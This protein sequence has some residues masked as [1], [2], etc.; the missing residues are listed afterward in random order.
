MKRKL[1]EI[2]R[3]LAW[4]P[5]ILLAGL[6]FLVLYTVFIMLEKKTYSRAKRG[7]PK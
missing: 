4:A 6:G 7:R 3:L 2:L 5:G 1:G